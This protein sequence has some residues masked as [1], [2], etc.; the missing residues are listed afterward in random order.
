MESLAIGNVIQNRKGEFGVVMG[1]NKKPYM[2]IFHSWCA[3]ITRWD[4]NL[5]HKNEAYDIVAVFDGKK[6]KD[7]KEVYSRR[8][9]PTKLKC[10]YVETITTKGKSRS[11]AKAKV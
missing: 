2:A 8:F 4:E 5:K 6:I 10:L 7:Y 1:M 11:K 3:P 9:D